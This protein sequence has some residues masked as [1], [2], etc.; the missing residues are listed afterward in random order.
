VDH[1]PPLSV[2]V[3]T[4]QG[5]RHL[6][7]ALSG[8]LAQGDV[9]FELIVSD[10]RSDDETLVVAR[11]VAGDR[12]RIEVNA[13]R[14]GLAGNWNRCMALA[15]APLVAIFHQDDVM[16]SGHLAAQLGTFRAHPDVGF[17]CGP[18]DVIDA[19]GRTLVQESSRREV[20][21]YAPGTF[22]AELA[23]CNPVRCSAVTIRKAAHAAVG[24][25]DAAYR[26]VVDWDFWI[27]VARDWPVAWLANPTVAVRWHAASETHRFR[28]GSADLEEAARLLED[29]Y[30]RDGPTLP[31][32]RRLRREADRHLARAYLNRAYEAS[33]GG[34]PA[35]VRTCLR[36]AV[37][38]APGTFGRAFLDP[39]FSFRALTGLSGRASGPPSTSAA[40][41]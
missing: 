21:T 38:L 35:L 17:V 12:A 22:L 14:L 1:P 34:D 9:D 23:A 8:I 15:R 13:E 10:D 2:A 4:Y 7:E 24:G 31:Q 19:E 18:A 29:L 40:L 5:A 26:Y 41:P 3:P 32:A 37:R 28:T 20:R 11:E 27:R 6:A 25:F 36:R 16:R 30:A 39:R 33:R